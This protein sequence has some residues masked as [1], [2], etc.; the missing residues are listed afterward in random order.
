M[1]RLVMGLVLV[2][3]MLVAGCKRDGGGANEGGPPT[4]PPPE[5]T[6]R[7]GELRTVPW[8]MEFTGTTR[9]FESVEIR[10]R[11]RG[12]IAKKRVRGGERVNAG[13]V[14][15]EIDPREYQATVSQMEADVAAKQAAQRLA[16]VTLERVQEAVKQNAVSKLEADRAQAD[17]DAAQAQVKLAEARLAQAKLDLE[18]TKVTAPIAG[19][20][21]VRMPDEGTLVGAGEM[22]LLTTIVD[23][24]KLYATYTINER[25]LLE[26]RRANQNRRPNEDGRGG[27]PVRLGLAD[28]RGYP[29]EGE[30]VRAD[31]TVDPAT[32]TIAI[33]AV[34]PNP[35]GTLLPGLFVRLQSILG[36]RSLLL[37]PESAVQA[38][39][40]GRFVWVI[41]KNEKGATTAQQRRVEIGTLVENQRAIVDGLEIN[42]QVIVNGFVRV[43]PGM[44]VKPVPPPPAA[45]PK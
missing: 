23:D 13:D 43:R 30:F 2:T 26:L 12:Y 18:W 39:Q 21:G 6:V 17:L 34:F 27:V 3:L 15:F 14:L 9:A 40:R 22:T 29:H 25:D 41:A 24:S 45:S 11:V 19:R 42:D 31:N 10:A 28:E 4:A 37:V 20:L 5:V 38:D 16:N 1:N 8:T 36:E 33:E 35:E 7:A 32:G 44:V